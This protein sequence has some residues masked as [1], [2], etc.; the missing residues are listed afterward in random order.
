MSIRYETPEETPEERQRGAEERE[1]MWQSLAAEVT[2]R[3]PAFRRW[4]RQH[5]LIFGSLSAI[6]FCALLAI[7]IVYH[8]KARPNPRA[9]A[10]PFVVA[11][12]IAGAGHWKYM[13]RVRKI[14]SE[15]WSKRRADESA[16][17]K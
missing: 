11:A 14:A 10:A 6:S 4:R 2:D 9:F 5:W 12:A 13:S 16:R 15:V 17:A 8:D 1:A 3:D 7:T